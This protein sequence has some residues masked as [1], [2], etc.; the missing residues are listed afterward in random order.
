MGTQYS[1]FTVCLVTLKTLQYA[2]KTLL[3]SSSSS[4]VSDGIVSVEK[5]ICIIRLRKNSRDMTKR[6]SLH[7]RQQCIHVF[8]EMHI[9]V[10]YASFGK[11]TK[12][13]ETE[14]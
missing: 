8:T 9:L 7:M 10:G 13:Q 14:F 1:N 12:S 6:K 3:N 11:R 4:S 5:N 2:L